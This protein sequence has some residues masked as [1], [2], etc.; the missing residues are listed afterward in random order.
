MSETTARALILFGAACC[1]A[2]CACQARGEL[3]PAPAPTDTA[4]AT[5][6]TDEKAMSNF[7]KPSEAELKKRLTDLQYQVT[8]REG[9]EQ[10]FRNAYWDNHKDGIYVDVVSGEPLF[11][12]K[13]KFDSGTGWPSFTRPLEPGNVTTKTDR[14]LLMSRTEVRSK[15][16]A[17][18]L[19][20]LFDDGPAPTGLRYCM[21]SASLRFVPVEQLAAEGYGRYL[22]LFGLAD[23]GAHVGVPAGTHA[24][25]QVDTHASL[26]GSGG[27][28][29]ILIDDSRVGNPA[30]GKSPGKAGHGTPLVATGK[31]QLAIFGQGCF[32]GVEERFRKVPGVVATAVGYAGGHAKDPSYEDV[33][34]DST[35]HAEVVLVEFDP[36]KVSYE[37]LLQ[38]FWETH[39]PTSGNAQGPDHGTQYRSAILTFGPAQQK[40]AEQSRA[41]AQQGLASAITT[42]IAP[43][44][45]FWI[46]EDYHQQWDEKHGALSCPVPHRAHKK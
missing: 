37:R 3:A 39:D 42:E 36:E 10:P 45:Q 29:P 9:T 1:A 27:D 40:L 25:T 35:G 19:G 15:Q 41:Q 33:C 8:Q 28:A 7:T 2:L 11:S 13:D 17:S 16:A 21:N 34:S 14:S 46:A 44:G 43:A 26:P 23:P 32:W 22:P 38:F 12:S 5:P 30:C 4:T 18:H 6:A 20:H 24:G 31:N